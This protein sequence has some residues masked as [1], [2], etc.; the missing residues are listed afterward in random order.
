M[1]TV[2][3]VNWPTGV[4]SFD[5]KLSEQIDKQSS[6]ISGSKTFDIPFSVSATGLFQIPSIRFSYFDEQT[7]TY[8]TLSSDSLQ[9]NVTAA[10]KRKT[11]VF[12]DVPIVEEGTPRWVWVASVGS[13]LLVLIGGIFFLQ[14]KKEKKTEIKIAIEEESEEVQPQKTIEAY[15]QPA[16]YVQQGLQPKQFYS[17]L[18]QGLQDFMNDRLLLQAQNI[19]STELVVALQQ[20]QWPDLAQELQQITEICELALFS[21]LQLTDDRE[22]LLI[23]ANNFMDQLDSRII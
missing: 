20:K 18:L 15:L 13:G 21:P 1:I 14:H 7:K 10:V 23:R 8:H 12:Q 22:Q 6:P 19:S 17:L 11:P 9:L 2:P 16:A 4:D 3:T 5:A